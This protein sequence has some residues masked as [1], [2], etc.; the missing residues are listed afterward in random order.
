MAPGQRVTGPAIIKEPTGT[1]VIEP[2]WQAE[3]N[4][5]GHLIL[6]RT[7]PL[8]RAE[9]VGT[10]ADPVMLEVFNNLFMSIAEQMGATLANTAYSVNIKERL[11]FSCALFDPTGGLV[12]NAPHVPVHLGSM[13]ESIRTVIRLNPDMKPGDVFVL[14]APFNGGTHLP[15]VTV[16][17]PVFGDDGAALFYVASRGHHADIGGKTPGSGPPDSTHIEE[18]GVLIDNFKMID[19]GHFREAETRALLAS[20]RYPCRNI[21]ENMADLAAQVAANETGVREVQKMIRQ[22]GLPTVH[23]Y[24]SHVQDNAE[25]CVRRVITALRDGTYDYELDNGEFIRVAVRV[26]PEARTA[27]IDFTGTADKNPFNYNAP[28][29]VCHAVVL[30]VFRTLVGAEIPLNEGCFKPLKI[31]A[32]EGSMINAQYPSAVIAGN[33]EVSQLMCNA[34]MGALGVMAGS[35]ATMNNYIWGNDR[36]QN[37]ETICGGTGA[38]PDFDGCSAVQT[39][40]TNTRGTDPEMLEFRFP[41]RLE[42]Y[43]IRR[44][45][46]GAGAHRG[47]DGITRRMRFLEQMTVTTLCSHRRVPPFGA[48]GGAPGDV[49]REWIERADGTRQE[50]KGNYQNELCPGDVFVMQ[51]PSGGGFGTVKGA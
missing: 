24:M 49:G 1:N 39:H 40:M 45:S 8:E 43:A 46:G 5:Y 47:G 3:I 14:N 38:G 19:G 22:F 41:V 35:Q 48:A 36:V 9:A 30:Y 27:E 2:D 50:H 15:D 31:I 16:I 37:Y 26:N 51:T 11:D 12:A 20:G 32:P 13:S 29:A 6:T 33:T 34:L 10:D 42:E 44:G 18:E 4:A 7:R 28:L 25:E 17:T 23:A 21:E